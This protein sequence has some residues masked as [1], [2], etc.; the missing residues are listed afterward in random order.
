MRLYRLF[1][2]A[3]GAVAC[4][5]VFA[6]TAEESA[7]RNVDN[8]NKIISFLIP[9]L[10]PVF[11]DDQKDLL[12]PKRIRVVVA[13]DFNAFADYSNRRV[14][15]PAQIIYECHSQAHAL[16]LVYRDPSLAPAY[17]RWLNRWNKISI[18]SKQAFLA[19][20][21]LIDDAPRPQFWEYL[22]WKERP[23]FSAKE[24]A[25]ADA[26]IN[27]AVALMVAHELGHLVL[28]HKGYREITPAKSRQQ[29]TEADEF[30]R[31]LLLRADIPVVPGL[32][33]Y[34]IRFAQLEELQNPD[35]KTSTHPKPECRFYAIGYR[36]VARMMKLPN[37]AAD[38]KRMG[39]NVDQLNESMKQL[40]EHC[41]SR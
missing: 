26:M 28:K 31:K 29:E 33:M 23:N 7:Q 19:G 17:Q 30:A 25:A 22:G 1:V 34:F 8:G 10:E 15:I 39:M 6:E 5:N 24:M 2:A 38:L 13:A 14:L 11:P 36:E 37:A 32:L 21:T 18:K 3:L 20:K 9:K 41:E 35:P 16:T 12:S 40:K 4:M 27:E